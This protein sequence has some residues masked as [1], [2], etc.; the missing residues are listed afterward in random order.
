MKILYLFLKRLIIYQ[1]VSLF[2]KKIKI[3]NTSEFI[4]SP[5]NFTHVFFLAMLTKK[6]LKS[7]IFF[8]FFLNSK[9]YF[10]R[11]SWRFSF[12]KQKTWFLAKSICQKSLTSSFQ[13]RT[14]V[15][16]QLQSLYYNQILKKL[17]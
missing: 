17:M 14:S 9:H 2:S 7:R 6:Y 11:S 3:C 4:V 13:F 16:T 8:F 12:L 5:R 10:G 15:I 1:E